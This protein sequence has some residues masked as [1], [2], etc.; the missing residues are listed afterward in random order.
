MRVLFENML[1]L[2]SNFGLDIGH[3]IGK[4]DLQVINISFLA[5][6][7]VLILIQI[8]GTILISLVSILKRP[9]Q[10]QSLIKGINQTRWIYLVIYFSHFIFIRILISILIGATFLK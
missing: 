10:S 1:K 4:R 3:F 2:P 9:S 7:G 8:I 6:S 5:V